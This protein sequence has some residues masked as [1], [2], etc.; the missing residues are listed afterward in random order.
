LEGRLL[1]VLGVVLFSG[2]VSSAQ[3]LLAQP[4]EDLGRQALPLSTLRTLAFKV[5]EDSQCEI[6]FGLKGYEPSAD[7][8]TQR[9]EIANALNTCLR[10]SPTIPITD[11]RQ[12]LQS[13]LGEE[14]NVLRSRVDLF[15][16]SI[17]NLEATRFSPTTRLRGMAR[18]YLGGLDYTGNQIGP[19]NTYLAGN[20]SG[21]PQLLPLQNAVTMSYDLQLNLDTSFTGK[22]LLRT[23]LRA[24]DGALSGLRGN[25]VTPMV[26]IDGVSPFC[27]PSKQLQ[28]NCRNNLVLLD[29]LFYKTPVGSSGLT[30]TLGPRL[31]QKDML[32]LWPS[33]YGSSERILSAFDYAGAVGAYSDVKGAGIGL[34]WKQPGRKRQY[35]VLSAV[36]AAARADIASPNDGGLLNATSRGAATVQL[37]YVGRNWVVAGVYTYNQAGARQDEIITPLAGETWP[38]NQPGLKGSVNAFGISGY[39]DPTTRSDW[40]PAISVGWGLNQNHYSL[41]GTNAASPRLSVQTQSWMLSLEWRDLF[42]KGNGLG[43]AVGQPKYV[44]QFVNSNGESGAFDSSWLFEAWYKIQVTDAIALTPAIFWLPRPRGQLTQAGTSWSDAALPTSSGATL[45]VLGLILKATIRF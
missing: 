10:Q 33:M 11:A 45:R 23:R 27:A 28:G 20:P 29:K 5:L 9:F 12:R 26:R 35:W 7:L 6:P 37:G 39:W 34:N 22:D 2:L 36:Y 16:A 30:L 42:D 40:Y 4:L 43:L 13:E 32:G 8:S 15:S 21:R 38:S 31:T 24:G 14:L 25:L 41:T 19:G 1:S 18:W 3:P 17:S 44:T